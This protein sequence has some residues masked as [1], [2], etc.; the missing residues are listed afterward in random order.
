MDETWVHFYDPEWD[1]SGSP[2]PLKF[3]V[4]KSAEG[5]YFLKGLRRKIKSFV[6]KGL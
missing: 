4:Q 5:S 2:R 3:F 1:H 6:L